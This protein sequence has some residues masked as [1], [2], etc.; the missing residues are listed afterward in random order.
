MAMGWRLPYKG[1]DV[2]G[3]MSFDDSLPKDSRPQFPDADGV[4]DVM[5]NE[6]PDIDSLVVVGGKLRKRAHLKLTVPEEMTGDGEDTRDIIV[7]LLDDKEKRI[8][9]GERQVEVEFFVDRGRLSALKATTEKG[10]AKVKLT[11]PADTT[12]MRVSATAP[13]VMWDIAVVKLVP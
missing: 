1:E 8:G 5:E 9:D 11:A 7:E 12:Y 10:K 13:K 4:I 2:M 6:V 3:C